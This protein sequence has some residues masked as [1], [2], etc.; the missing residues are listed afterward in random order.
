VPVSVA[1]PSETASIKL[2]LRDV[3]G[4]TV[5]SWAVPVSP[6]ASASTV[7]VN[8]TLGGLPTATYSFVAIATRN[9]AAPV[10]SDPVPVRVDNTTT[11]PSTP[12]ST[13]PTTPPSTP[14]STPTPEPPTVTPPAM[15]VAILSPSPNAVVQGVVPVFVSVPAQTVGVMIQLKTVGG[16]PVVTTTNQ[17]PPVGS[18]TTVQVNAALGGLPP[19]DYLLVASAMVAG[20]GPVTSAPVPV[21]IQ[22]SGPGKPPS[23]T[24][25]PNAAPA[26]S[27]LPTGARPRPEFQQAGSARASVRGTTTTS[28]SANAEASGGAGPS[29]NTPKSTAPVV[30]KAPALPA[31]T[32]V[33]F[34]FGTCSGEDPYA[35]HPTLKGECV[36]GTWFPR[37]RKA[38]PR[39]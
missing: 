15:E 18:A 25:P 13:P 11:P 24:M 4:G 10:V 1:V 36:S 21:H 9:G 33:T 28:D 26:K 3:S 16:I 8:A 22:S 20:V 27:G 32:L 37:V 14:P 23:R 5:T 7:Q 29:S 19:N 31:G 39:R 35:K 38:E 17:M 12:P 2:E 34:G 30:A 6:S